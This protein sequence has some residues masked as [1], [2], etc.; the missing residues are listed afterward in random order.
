MVSDK[1]TLKYN[2]QSGGQSKESILYP[3]CCPF[4]D[5]LCTDDSSD[6]DCDSKSFNTIVNVN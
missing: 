6:K 4:A 5:A 2:S 3:I 1:D